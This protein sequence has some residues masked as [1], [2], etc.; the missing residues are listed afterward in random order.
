MLLPNHCLSR[1]LDKSAGTTI[2]HGF[3]HWHLPFCVHLACKTTRVYQQSRCQIF[4][5]HTAFPL[6]LGEIPSPFSN[7]GHVNAFLLFANTSPCLAS[8]RRRR[9]LAV[10]RL[11]ACQAPFWLPGSLWPGMK[12][13][14]R[15]ISPQLFWSGSQATAMDAVDWGDKKVEGGELPWPAFSPHLGL[16][17]RLPGSLFSPESRPM[18]R[19]IV[20]TN[21]PGLHV[22]CAVP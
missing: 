11:R 2:H 19:S 15:R 16:L 4:W 5:P 17:H 10:L 13:R 7:C 14:R 8:R 22:G 1:S 21:S 6:L 12:N 3:R 18:T 20:A 9:R